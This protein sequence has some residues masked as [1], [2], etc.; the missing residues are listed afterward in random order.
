TSGS[1]GTFTFPS[2]SNVWSVDLNGNK[3]NTF[4]VGES[5]KVRANKGYNGTKTLSVGTNLNKPAAL[6]YDGSGG[7]QDIVKY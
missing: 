2:D 7:F 1:S 3:K 5:F 6:K 4:T